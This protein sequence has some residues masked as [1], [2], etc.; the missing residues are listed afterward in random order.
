MVEWF[1]RYWVDTIGHK[2]RTTI[3][4]CFEPSRPTRDYTRADT[5]LQTDR[6]IPIPPP[7]PPPTNL[8]IQGGIIKLK[9]HMYTT[10]LFQKSKNISTRCKSAGDIF[11]VKARERGTTCGNFVCA[12]GCRGVHGNIWHAWLPACDRLPCALYSKHI[13]DLK[14]RETKINQHSKEKN[15]CSMNMN[16]KDAS[17]ERQ[18]IIYCEEEQNLLFYLT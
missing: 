2:D 9:C 8:F 5:E 6:V 14:D 10:T 11:K 13:L 3:S 1:R 7:L 16:W 12:D 18:V 4:W 15:N 17:T